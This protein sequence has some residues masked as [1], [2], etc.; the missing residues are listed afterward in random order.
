VTYTHS[1]VPT[2]A[3]VNIQKSLDGGAGTTGPTGGTGGTGATGATGNGETGV[4]GGTGQTGGTGP[5]GVIGPQGDAGETGAT[6][7]TGATGATGAGTTGATGG[8]MTGTTGPTGVQGDVGPTGAA[9]I[10]AQLKIR[11]T[12]TQLKN[13]LTTGIVLVAADAAKYMVPIMAVCRVVQGGVA[14]EI[15]TEDLYISFRGYGSPILTLNNALLESAVTRTDIIMPS[16]SF[17]NASSN[18]DLILYAAADCSAGTGG[19][20]EITLYYLAAEEY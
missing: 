3:S 10:G 16:G 15:G 17:V 7:M 1:G 19:Y 5:T 20:L 12:D 14:F 6:G 11:I 2:T 18:V 8:G 4:T 13:N 9:G